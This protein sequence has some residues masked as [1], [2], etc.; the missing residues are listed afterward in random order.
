MAANRHRLILSDFSGDFSSTFPT[1]V[2]AH[3]NEPIKHEYFRTFVTKIIKGMSNIPEEEQ[4]T[5]ITETLNY[6]VGNETPP[7]DN[8][9][10]LGKRLQDIVK[11]AG[12]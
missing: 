6:V 9:E 12:V 2:E 5:L 11:N 4:P 3:Q 10:T 1:K 7:Y 8:L